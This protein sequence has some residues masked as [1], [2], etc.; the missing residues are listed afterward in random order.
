ME[1]PAAGSSIVS[2][3]DAAEEELWEVQGR[4][5]N[6]SPR[7]EPQ[8]ERM[9]DL[10]SS[11]TA[12]NLE[13]GCFC[14]PWCV[15]VGVLQW[16]TEEERQGMARVW[17]WLDRLL[18][19]SAAMQ[20]EN[21]IVVQHLG[22]D[23]SDH[24]PLLLS[25]ATRLDGKLVPFRF[26]NVWVAKLGFLDVV[27]ESWST[28]FTG[29]PLKTTEQKVLEAEISHDTHLSDE[30]LLNL[31]KAC[32]RLRNALVVEEEFWRQKARVKWLCNGDKNTKFFHAVVT[33]RRRKSVIHR[34]R[35]LDGVWVDDE[36]SICNEAV[37]FFRALFTE[38][39]GRTSSYMLEEI[40]DVIFSM[41]AE[42]AAGS[43]GF[44]GRFFTAAW[45]VITE[46]V[47]RRF[48]FSEVWI[49]MIWRLIS[50]V[51][52]SVI[53]NGLPHGF[54]KSTRG[55]RQGDPISSALF[56][57]GAEVHS[58]SLNALA[59]HRRFKLFRIPSGC[60]MAT[61]LAFVGDVVIFTSSLKAS[62]HSVKKVVNGY[63]SVSGQ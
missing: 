21:T 60:P 46:D 31:Q 40:K 13:P 58:R 28:A 53:M 7:G 3:V 12:L 27:K 14:S 41:D 10:P 36:S 39:G 4:V 35:K 16:P 50:N 23:P 30:L 8:K 49:D 44:A 56:V 63:C 59:E 52:F 32:A 29:S 11:S 33:E 43:D 25:A 19:N 2:E 17:K 34:I 57:I 9:G 38:D 1:Q 22:R 18:L 61:H 45:E 6:L 5:G 48:G 15:R 47:L 20:M 54:F 37:F 55:L 62:I 26:L 51:W 24:A 42:S